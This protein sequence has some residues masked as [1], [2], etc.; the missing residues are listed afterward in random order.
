MSNVSLSIYL[1]FELLNKNSKWH[2]YLNIFPELFNNPL[3]F[4]LN[5]IEILKP[6]Q[7]FSKKLN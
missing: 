6:S 7:S 5:D 2:S 4:N 3:Y 1:L